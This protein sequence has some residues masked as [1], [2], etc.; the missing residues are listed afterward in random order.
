MMVRIFAVAVACAFL[1][2]APVSAK[3]YRY[4]SGVSGTG[5]FP[6]YSYEP[7]F[8]QIKELTKGSVTFK[9]FYNGQL[10]SFNN[11]LQGVRDGIVDAGHVLWLAY[12]TELPYTSLIGFMVPL[13]DNP[14]AT[15]GALTELF[16]LTCKECL[17]EFAKSGVFVYGGEPGSA[18]Q[19]MCRK[20]IAQLSDL[21]GLRV[22]AL[23]AMSLFASSIGMTSVRLTSSEILQAMERGVIDCA[24]APME[25][26]VDYSLE[27]V[28]TH[29][30]ESHSGLALGGGTMWINRKTWNGF[31][32]D[33]R[34]AFLKAL[35]DHIYR[36]SMEA[37]GKPAAEAR[38]RA[39]AKG[40]KF[41]DGGAAY[42]KAWEDYRRSGTIKNML[43]V[44]EK[45]GVPE[46]KAKAFVDH[47]VGTFD[48]WHKDLLPKFGSDREKFK[49]VLI[50]EV[51]SKLP[52]TA[53]KN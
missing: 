12:P 53:A 50:E 47:V 15:A 39:V 51:I 35:P 3:E 16:M 33:E 52:V 28:V 38:A 26:L 25:W 13:A 10:I 20:D 45:R 7:F 48:R 4:G 30:F 31:T 36:S 44:L 6:K 1:V 46:D 49:A 40:I 22:R 11:S 29:V 19:L 34:R 2:A 8:A 41:S 18:Y 43:G 37:Y 9:G 5:S 21:K 27:D 14:L 42:K 17:E 23:G 32:D 24:T